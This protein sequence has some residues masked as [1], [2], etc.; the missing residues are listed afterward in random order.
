NAV[1]VSLT[2]HDFK[3]LVDMYSSS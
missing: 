1:T 3:K 2:T